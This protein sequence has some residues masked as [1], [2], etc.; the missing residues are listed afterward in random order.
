MS[1]IEKIKELLASVI[2]SDTDILELRTIAN[3]YL[4]DEEITALKDT[5]NLIDEEEE[6]QKLED[7][8]LLWLMKNTETTNDPAI[9]EIEG[10]VVDGLRYVSTEVGYVDQDEEYR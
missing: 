1:I 2:L 9:E 8:H 4:T 5:Q 10:P 7:D 6:R 3:S